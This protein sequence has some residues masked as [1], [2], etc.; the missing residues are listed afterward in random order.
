VK[1]LGRL[2]AAFFMKEAKVSVKALIDPTDEQVA[3]Y[4]N[5]QL[6]PY[7]RKR[8]WGLS[9]IA[10]SGIPALWERSTPSEAV[11]VTVIRR[12]GDG[13]IGIRFV[14]RGFTA[15]CANGYG[16]LNKFPQQVIQCICVLQGRRHRYVSCATM[17]ATVR[18]RAGIGGEDRAANRRKALTQLH[19]WLSP[20]LLLKARERRTA[21]VRAWYW[22]NYVAIDVRQRRALKASL[23]DP[24]RSAEI[25]EDKR[26]VLIRIF[27]GSAAFPLAYDRPA[28]RAYVI[29][30]DA[31]HP[32]RMHCLPVP[33]NTESATTGL[34][35]CAGMT[36]AEYEQLQPANEA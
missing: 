16:R 9:T 10:P 26:G 29:V 8:Q 20:K 27:G 15:T 32:Q 25:S 17:L 4:I 36:K 5:Q 30:R 18:G 13:E 12:A 34:A 6:R 21:V 28:L 22:R 24:R 2:F 3:E 19:R 14:E 11:K 35:W 31:T 33:P 7:R 23:A 1:V